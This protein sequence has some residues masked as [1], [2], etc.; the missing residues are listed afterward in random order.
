MTTNGLFIHDAPV[1]ATRLREL[2]IAE[3][4]LISP[5]EAE[6][7]L[8][9]LVTNAT[10]VPSLV[11][12]GQHSSG[13]SML[14]KALTDGQAEVVIDADVATDQVTH[15]DWDG[16]V[17]LVDT[18]GVQ[19]GIPEHDELAWQALQAADLILFVTTPDLFDDLSAAH[20][21]LIADG[22]GKRDQTM[23]V[24]NK[25]K[26]MSADPG[27]REKA[28]SQLFDGTL[29]IP[30]VECD[31]KQY[32]RSL[33][34]SDP[35]LRAHLEST[36]GIHLLRASINAFASRRGQLALL[37]QPFQLIR[38]LAAEA[39]SLLVEDENERVILTWLA[40]MRRTLA[41][42]RQSLES[43]LHIERSVFLAAALEIAEGYADDLE[44]I[45]D[46]PPAAW[47]A[48]NKVFTQTSVERL[49][50]AIDKA[51]ERMRQAVERAFAELADEVREIEEGPHGRIIEQFNDDASGQ[52]KTGFQ[53]LKARRASNGKASPDSFSRRAN[54]AQK[55]LGE[56]RNMWGAGEG[57][58]KSAGTAGHRVVKEVGSH[59][60]KKW[61]PWEAVRWADRIGK[62]VKVAGVTLQVAGALYGV[63]AEERRELQVE[64]DR[65]HRRRV[66]VDELMREARDNID[67]YLREL[68]AA[69]DRPFTV[70]FNEIDRQVSAM[71]QD[72]STRRGTR[73]R[74]IAI[75]EDCARM[76]ML[77]REDNPAVEAASS[78]LQ[79]A[80]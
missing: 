71:Q 56:F 5:L 72:D 26:T 16:S 46:V 78:S 76:T 51:I 40:R 12:T 38:S 60:G 25:A 27:L 15:Y 63:Y 32:V 24:V 57:A 19:A 4:H 22:L 50:A 48:H 67:D 20:L 39:E 30:F 37:A 66:V 65:V 13:K 42:H 53:G 34:E 33:T 9:R 74:L 79:S 10:R 2:L 17:A 80:L 61:R 70:A 23:I 3:L 49:N 21:R 69:I 64:R 28:I 62:A 58:R 55:L 29:T 36:S 75:Q 11:F 54:Q 35:E 44:S 14:I 6:P 31:A 59:F 52:Q 41:E 43:A 73:A 7:M 8:A 77:L 18:P 68:R 45:D 1:E 47:E